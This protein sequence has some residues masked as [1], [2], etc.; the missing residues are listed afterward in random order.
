MR[1]RH[2]RHAIRTPRRHHDPSVGCLRRQLSRVFLAALLIALLA[3]P[4]AGPA[5]AQSSG[6]AAGTRILG[7]DKLSG[8]ALLCAQHPFIRG[9]SLCST[10]WLHGASPVIELVRNRYKQY[11]TVTTITSDDPDPSAA[12]QSVTVNFSVTS[13]DG[14]PT[15]N[16]TVSDGVDLCTGTVAAGTCSLTL[17]TPGARTLT[18]TYAGRGN[19]NGSSDTEP[20]QVNKADTTTT[21]TSDDPDPSSVGQSLTVNFSVT[22]AGGTPTGGVT[23]SDGVDSCTATVAAGAC[24]LTLT[25]PGARPLTASYAGDAN[26]N[27]SSDTEPHSVKSV[28]F[29]P[30]ILR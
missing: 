26:F 22:S 13:A 25:T 23:V 19:Y 30:L 2:R 1:T 7:G 21:I 15:G 12:G 18:A 11:D 4:M 27:G 16:V 9:G 14:T 20:H 10:G 28:V 29:L 24:S 3:P 5:H 8:L 17:T 6:F